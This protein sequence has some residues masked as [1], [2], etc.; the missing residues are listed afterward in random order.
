MKIKKYFNNHPSEKK[1]FKILII[2]LGNAIIL[3]MNN[4]VS[5][6]PIEKGSNN[7]VHIFLYES[8]YYVPPFNLLF[9]SCFVRSFELEED[10]DR[11]SGHSLLISR[12]EE[13]PYRENS[14]V[15]YGMRY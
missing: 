8:L 7:I 1:L 10:N 2:P 11:K 5:M 6:T 13:Y 9:Y 4:L 3:I 14:S 12:F 15:V